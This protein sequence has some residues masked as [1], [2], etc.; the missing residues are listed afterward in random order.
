MP[1]KSFTSPPKTL[2]CLLYKALYSLKQ[3]AILWLK[4]IQATLKKL[5]FLP[6]HSDECV[7]QNPES[8]ILVVTY[9]DD[10]L[11]FGASIASIQDLKMRLKS[12]LRMEDLRPV[13]QYCGTRVIRDR[14]IRSIHLVQDQYMEKVLKAFWMQDCSTVSTP[15]EVGAAVYMVSSTDPPDDV[16]TQEYQSIV[17]SGMYAMT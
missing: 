11:V 3:S 17:G 9:V 2:V 5:G 6:L 1:D 15:M 4:K 12:K 14:A 10:F 8:R 13:Q 7:Y 16:R